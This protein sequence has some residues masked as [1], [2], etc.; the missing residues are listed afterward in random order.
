[1]GTKLKGSVW[2]ARAEGER[3][4]AGETFVVI[5]YFS[6]PLDFED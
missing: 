6:F 2:V 1:M 5:V 3:W 4:A